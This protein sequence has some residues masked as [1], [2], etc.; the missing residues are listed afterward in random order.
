MFRVAFRDGLIRELRAWEWGGSEEGGLI[1]GKT[2]AADETRAFMVED[3]Q[4]SDDSE[5]SGATVMW[6]DQAR[7]RSIVERLPAAR[8]VIGVYHQHPPDESTAPSSADIEAGKHM[9]EMV[10]RPV[11]EIIVSE[12]RE[13]R[14]GSWRDTEIHAFV[15]DE[16]GA[17]DTVDRFD[18]PEHAFPQVRTAIGWARDLSADSTE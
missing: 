10:G 1:L 12:R 14:T 9:A 3:L 18:V 7:L 15:V 13:E 11:L 17:V 16:N 6:L 8:S 2:D 5:K 4:P